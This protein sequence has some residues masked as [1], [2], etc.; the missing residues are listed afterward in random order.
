MTTLAL[1]AVVAT[2]A[3]VRAAGILWLRP[4]PALPGRSPGL[5]LR[6]LTR[7]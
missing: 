1:L 7:A 2:A 6:R 5:T 4:Q 3:A